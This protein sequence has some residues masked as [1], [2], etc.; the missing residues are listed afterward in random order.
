LHIPKHLNSNTGILSKIGNKGNTV[1][2]T[3]KHV[4]DKVWRTFA[5]LCKIKGVN[6]GEELTSV[7]KKYVK[8]R[9]K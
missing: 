6:I 5:G 7:L 1:T 8:E 3:I 4:D 9:L 2:K